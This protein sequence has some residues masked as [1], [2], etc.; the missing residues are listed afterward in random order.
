LIGN[1]LE[2]EIIDLYSDNPSSLFSINQ[3]ATKLGKKYPY[4]N[5]KVTIL[6]KNNI[7]KKTIVG[8]SHLCSLNLQ[9]D[10]T[11][12]LLIL[13]EIKRKKETFEV[14]SQKAAK[15]LSYSCKVAKASG[16]NLVL[17][18]KD[19]IF[20]V[21]DKKEEVLPLEKSIIP[22]ML[23]DLSPV[24]IDRAEF[25]SRLKKD[26]KLQEDKIIMLGF[27][28]YYDCIREIEDELKIKYSR[29]IP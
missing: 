18:I 20:F 9:N 6:V 24:I 28:K 1:A 3:I 13:N 26:P 22:Q 29:I 2:Q 19:E 15:I 11:I 10:E 23:Q 17:K 21:V 4:I 16:A 7:F 14:A 12:Y 25:L 27:E 8:R 5:K